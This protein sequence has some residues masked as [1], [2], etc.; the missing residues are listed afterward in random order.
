MRHLRCLF[1]FFL[2]T[3]FQLPS[4]AS[5]GEEVVFYEELLNYYESND[6]K[7]FYSLL[8]KFQKI[9][10]DSSYKEPLFTLAAKNLYENKQYKNA[11]FFIE[12]LDSSFQL[13]LKSYQAECYLQL[14]DYN[15]VVN[16]YRNIAPND[17]IS[18][19]ILARAFIGIANE[20]SI[21]PKKRAEAAASAIKVLAS[22]T[23]ESLP[24]D[25]LLA[26]SKLHFRSNQFKKS[27]KILQYLLKSSASNK[28][29]LLISLSSIQRQYNYKSAIKTLDE[30]LK[31]NGNL[32]EVAAYQ[33]MMILF[34]NKQYKTLISS[35]DLL[36]N[37]LNQEKLPLFQYYLGIAFLDN[38]EYSE[39]EKAFNSYLKN[40]T[41][42]ENLKVF[43]F[44]KLKAISDRKKDSL[45]KDS[46]FALAK[47]YIQSNQYKKS[48]KILKEILKNDPSNKEEVLVQLSLAQK[49]YNPHLAIRTLDEI[50]RLEG[51]YQKI[52]AYQ[53]MK[54]LFEEMQY[55]SLISSRSSLQKNLPPECLPLLHYFL[56]VAFLE[57]EKYS[58]AEIEFNSYLKDVKNYSKF[59]VTAKE[60]LKEIAEIKSILKLNYKELSTYKK[61][62]ALVNNEQ[63]NNLISSKEKFQKTLSPKRLPLLH[64]FL[65][66]AF[67]KNDKHLEAEKEFNAYLADT[68]SY[69]KYKEPAL[70]NLKVISDKKA[71]QK[72]THMELASYKKMMTL[73][74]NKKYSN[75]ISY[76]DKLQ[77]NLNSE[78]LPLLHYF[79][80]IAFL[81]NDEYMESEKEFNIYLSDAKNYKDLKLNALSYLKKIAEKK[82]DTTLLNNVEASIA[83]LDNEQSIDLLKKTPFKN[84]SRIDFSEALALKREKRFIEAEK[85]LKTLLESDKVQE[86]VA[87]YFELAHI[88]HLD[89]KYV[90]AKNS[91][92]SFIKNNPSSSLVPLAWN[93]YIE[94]SIDLAK[95]S[96]DKYAKAQLMY[97]TTICLK[98]NR[99]L[100]QLEWTELMFLLAKTQYELS[101]FEEAI[102]TINT[103]VKN[104][105]IESDILAKCYLVLGYSYKNGLGDNETF[106]FYIK[107]ATK[108]DPSLLKNKKI[109]ALLESPTKN[110]ATDVP[111][112]AD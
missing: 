86:K 85:I 64:Y 52:A 110:K 24:E 94:A 12:Q 4:F 98:H 9:Y 84:N 29:E 57:K 69:A 111:A 109:Q 1:V 108:V 91:F 68:K 56:G 21:D 106:I 54:I 2:I 101:S 50:I 61:M 89:A 96:D 104:K 73:F 63:Y 31:L 71:Q 5:S 49:K 26:L 77:K 95:N 41:D 90:K 81:K 15:Q 28:E 65:G 39:A 105:K 20:S 47:L 112:S 80:G 82:N 27:A 100:N 43:A 53:K 93:Y 75:L 79:L 32:K 76:K 33:K 92:M 19:Q 3:F 46:L 10:P 34:E 58:D 13:R 40:T 25:T 67:L 51:A 6:M 35:R 62:I 66:V 18:R 8:S 11:L 97:D 88:Y 45:S 102:E 70:E 42:Y 107:K 16:L 36:K 87:I 23:L 22:Q 72:T 14:K 78:S 103:L 17:L 59:K 7:K 48:A 38:N 30:A 99:Y 74:N 83:A 37:H 60:S 44:E 55:S